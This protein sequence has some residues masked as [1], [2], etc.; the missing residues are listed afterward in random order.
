MTQKNRAIIHQIIGI[1]RQ[2]S[3]RMKEIEEIRTIE[4]AFLVDSDRYLISVNE[5]EI[6]VLQA[7]IDALEGSIKLD[8]DAPTPK[9]KPV[10][11]LTQS[12]KNVDFVAKK[13]RKGA[14]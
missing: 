10:K 14:K 8:I 5:A 11:N 6:A 9:V 12:E 2:I 7:E 13:P 1:K 4:D 3:H